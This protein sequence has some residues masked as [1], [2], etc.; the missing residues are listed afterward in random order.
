M[1]E[2]RVAFDGSVFRLRVHLIPE[3]S[4]EV[5]MLRKCTDRLTANPKLVALYVEQKHRLVDA[6]VSARSTYTK[7]KSAFI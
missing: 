6:H 5:A 2:G 7:G 3:D 1:R 4:A